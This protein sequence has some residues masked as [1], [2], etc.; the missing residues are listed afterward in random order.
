MRSVRALLA[1]IRWPNALLAAAGVLVGA[2]W[3]GG[4][5]TAA[6]VLLTAGAA[7]ALTAVANAENDYRDR[8]IDATAHPGR[9]LPSGALRP[10]T[11][12]IVVAVAAIAAI[13]LALAVSAAMALATTAVVGAMIAYSPLLKPLGLPGNITVA[14]IASLPFVYGAWAVGTPSAALPLFTIAVPLHFAREL[15]KDLEDA[16]AD[17]PSRRTLPVAR[18]AAA[19]RIALVAALVPGVVVLT[20]MIVDRPRLGVLVIPA[21]VAAA[22]GTRRALRGRRGAPSLYKLA[23]ACAMASL[24]LAHWS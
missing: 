5:P 14:V 7:I 9:P 22:L 12:R 23:M 19:T 11:A 16:A 24:I 21:I 3:G 8:A 18:G 6:A 20:W 4:D 17:A 15:A 13:G 2:W 1:L 10:R